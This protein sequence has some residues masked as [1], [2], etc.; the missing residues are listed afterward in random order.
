[1]LIPTLITELIQLL[2]GITQGERNLGVQIGELQYK[3][4]KKYRALKPSNQ[5]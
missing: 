5:S 3:V 1:M 2:Y 4:P